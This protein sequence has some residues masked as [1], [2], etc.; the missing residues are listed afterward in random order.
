MIRLRLLYFI[1]GFFLCCILNGLDQKTSIKLPVIICSIYALII[2]V[3]EI[4]IWVTKKEEKQKVLYGETIK[5]GRI[6]GSG[7]YT[8]P[9]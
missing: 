9:Q 5:Q 4:D 1:L 2:T 3:G 8:G 7:I 6:P